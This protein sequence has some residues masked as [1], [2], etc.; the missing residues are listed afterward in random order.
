[1]LSNSCRWQPLSNFCENW[2]GCLGKIAVYYQRVHLSKILTYTCKKRQ[3]S[4][5]EKWCHTT[6]LK[7]QVPGLPLKVGV[8]GGCSLFPGCMSNFAFA[9]DEYGRVQILGQD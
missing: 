4:M 1:M 3:K 6:L 2:Q 5:S 7:G 9:T 8:G